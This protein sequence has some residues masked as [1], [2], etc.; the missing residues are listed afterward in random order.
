VKYALLLAAVLVVL[1]VVVA[2]ILFWPDGEDESEP[3]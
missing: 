2:A 1:G 3:G